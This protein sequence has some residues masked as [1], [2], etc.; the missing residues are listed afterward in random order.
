MHP[1]LLALLGVLWST[2]GF[3]L[4]PPVGWSASS[5][6]RAELVP[7]HPEKG[8]IRE[9]T[10][11]G[12]SGAADELTFLLQGQGLKATGVATDP[13]G[14]VNLSFDGK[15]GRARNIRLG[16]DVVWVVVTIATENA[17]TL[18]PDAVIR[19][20]MPSSDTPAWGSKAPSTTQVAATPWGEAAEPAQAGWLSDVTVE[21]WAN[22]SELMGSWEGSTLIAG[23]PTRIKMRFEPG[24]AVFVE[25]TTKDATRVVD[26]KWATRKSLI[27]LELEGGGDGLDY[28]VMGRTL[29]IEYA[30]ARV[31]L[32]RAG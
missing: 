13:D 3:A 1:S 22:D 31:T 20:A 7:G 29:N 11:S 15:I 12:G 24:G 8:E 2:P 25:R 5:P 32:Y 21:G 27:R 14:A 23:Q 10:V 17:T 18:D 4:T 16:S 30:D 19:M 28:Q 26:G 6:S 9:I